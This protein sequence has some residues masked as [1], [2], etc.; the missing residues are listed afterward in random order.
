[1]MSPRASRVADMR[2]PH[3]SGR[4]KRKTA[5]AGGLLC[6]AVLVGW[7]VL[8]CVQEEMGWPK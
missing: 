4:K 3:V 2:D 6:W 7:G 8:A 5:R 1:M